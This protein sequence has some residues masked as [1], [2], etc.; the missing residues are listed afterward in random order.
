MQVIRG[1]KAETTREEAL[2]VE[3]EFRELTD[4]YL[5]GLARVARRRGGGWVTAAEAGIR[6]FTDALTALY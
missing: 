1:G 2:T 4:A 5:T 3:Q 6:R